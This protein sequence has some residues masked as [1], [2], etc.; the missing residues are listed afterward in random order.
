MTE[1]QTKERPILFS[2]PMAKAILDGRKSQTRRLVKGCVEEAG[3]YSTAVWEHGK[4]PRCPYGTAGERLWVREAWRG[5][6]DGDLS[7]SVNYRADDT[8]RDF[9]VD[10]LPESSVRPCSLEWKWRPS[11]YMPRWASRILLEITGVRVERLQDISE[12]DCWAE[13]IEEVD[14]AF[15]SLIPDMARRI[16]MSHEDAK[17]TFACLWESINGNGSWNL[18]PWVWCVS[19]RR[20][21]K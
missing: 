9:Y 20:I 6:W 12:E 15:D 2:G 5:S 4:M 21:G 11:I 7:I 13:G 8:V 19:F 10:A 16:G 14:G 1:A 17:P 3:A 18:N